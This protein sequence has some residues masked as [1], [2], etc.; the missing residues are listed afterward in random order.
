MPKSD[1]TAKVCELK[2]ECRSRE[3]DSGALSSV[4][5]P[6]DVEAIMASIRSHVKR[7]LAERP[8][9]IPKYTPPAAELFSGSVSPVLY[10]DELNYLNAHWNDWLVGEQ[11]TSHR[12]FLGPLVVKVKEKLRRFVV[13]SLLPGYFEKEREFQGQLVRHLNASA[14]YIDARDAEIFWQ[15]VRKIDSDITAINE[16]TDRLF[17]EASA[18]LSEAESILD[19]RLRI[20][21]DSRKELRDLIHRLRTDFVGR[22]SGATGDS[23]DQFVNEKDRFSEYASN[24]AD[25]K[26]V[27][28]DLSCRGPEFLEAL[29]AHR[30]EGV[31]ITS[32]QLFFNLCEKKGLPVTLGRE[33]SYLDR[34]EDDSLGGI[35][36]IGILSGLSLADTEGLLE[37]IARKVKTGGK[38]VLEEEVCS[39]GRI[40]GH[41]S[42]ELRDLFRRKGISVTT[43]KSNWSGKLGKKL[44]KIEIS[45]YMPVRFRRMLEG[46]N[47]NTDKLNDLLFGG[48]GCLIVGEIQ[49]SSTNRSS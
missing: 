49:D 43:I 7:G 27:V 31:G 40:G 46:V 47:E 25:T 21:E 19:S 37:C 16:R 10:S 5:E 42:A 4:L 17:E 26:G 34:L 11:I 41:D 29:K 22:E 18:A 32:N 23:S 36:S 35:F 20:V 48:G 44:R 1:S 38:I 28:V 14:R 13:N 3:N 2:D 9:G 15:T 24:F 45:P 6:P 8:P 30:I 39:F 33:R 12:R